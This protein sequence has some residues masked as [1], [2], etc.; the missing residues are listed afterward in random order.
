[1]KRFLALGALELHREIERGLGV[2]L[3]VVGHEHILDSPSLRDDGD[4]LQVG[5]RGGGIAPAPLLDHLDHERGLWRPFRQ[6]VHEPK[7]GGG[8]PGRPG[9]DDHRQ[10]LGAAG[11]LRG[12]EGKRAGGRRLAPGPSRDGMV[13]ELVLLLAGGAFHGPRDGRL[14][15]REAPGNHGG[16]SRILL[17]L[18]RLLK[19]QLHL[20]AAGGQLLQPRIGRPRVG[21]C[22][23]L[24]GL[25]K[26]FR[27]LGSGWKSVGL[28]DRIRSRL[29]GG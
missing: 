8:I 24:H 21:L 14:G 1:M 7:G 10:Q 22:P 29:G 25:F 20:L 4:V 19:Q 9:I 28:G 12:G 23:R 27:V 3:R 6:G 26:L 18:G 2:L 5:D 15:I 11:P 13:Y 17:G 16:S